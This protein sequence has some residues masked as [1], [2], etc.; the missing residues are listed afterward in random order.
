MNCE[1]PE[2]RHEAY[3]QDG[4]G[5]PYYRFTPSSTALAIAIMAE[6][7][8]APKP[9]ELMKYR[10]IFVSALKAYEEKTG[11]VLSSDPLL[12]SFEKCHSPSDIFTIL[13]QQIPGIGQSLGRHSSLTGWLTPTVNIIDQFSATTDGAIGLVSLTETDTIHP[14]SDPLISIL[15]A[16]TPAGLIFTAIGVLL[17]VNIST[18]SSQMRFET[19][20]ADR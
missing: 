2:P 14:Q 16:H 8:W 15:Q 1:H 7:S 11:K 3:I 12:P 9:T 6:T 10:S 19:P 4:F 20:L 18:I 5:P 13:R 17:S